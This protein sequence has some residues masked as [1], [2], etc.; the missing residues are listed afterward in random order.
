MS[1]VKVQIHI[2]SRSQS[3]TPLPGGS[4]VSLLKSVVCISGHLIEV[5]QFHAQCLDGPIIN[6]WRELTSSE[7]APESVRCVH[8][9]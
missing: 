8:F 9:T 7:Y 6:I 3:T 1:F 4:S 5:L 2:E